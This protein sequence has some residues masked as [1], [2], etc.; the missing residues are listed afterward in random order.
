MQKERKNA[1]LWKQKIALDEKSAKNWE[2]KFESGKCEHS[3]FC[4][5]QVPLAKRPRFWKKIQ[6]Q[7]KYRRIIVNGLVLDL[8]RR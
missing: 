2:V 7:Q 3:E 8:D 5:N 4:E 1:D 6:H